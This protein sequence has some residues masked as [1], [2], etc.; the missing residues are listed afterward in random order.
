VYLNYIKM[1][2]SSRSIAAARARRSNEQPP[3]V[4]GNRPITSI[5]SQAAFSQVP[6]PPSN[7]RVSRG[8]PPQQ[9]QQ[10]QM[11]QQIPPQMQQQ[12]HQQQ[13]QH[14]QMQQQQMYQQMPQQMQQSEPTP[15][16][17]TKLSISD[18]IG[19]I[20]LR[21]GR[22]EQFIIELEHSEEQGNHNLP[23]NVKMVDNSIFNNISSRLDAIEKKDPS[24]VSNEQI[25]LINEEIKT[26]QEGVK[27]LNDEIVKNSLNAAKHSE[28]MLRFEREFVENKDILKTLLIKFDLFVRE[29]NEK[30]IDY[31]SA[32]VE[33]EKHFPQ[34]FDETIES[35]ENNIDKSQEVDGGEI[36]STNIMTVDLKNIIKQELANEN[37]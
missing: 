33:L 32:I 9:M 34:E 14:Q 30:F 8:P 29:T 21:L 20:T 12:M 25:G 6:P 26:I 24:S 15:L 22:V 35:S 2:S 5:G 10:Q 37:I 13:M 31:E 36:D 19:L 4:N 3:P 7:I 28:Q 17:F 23:D 16:P 1:S 11:Y 27:R 18:A